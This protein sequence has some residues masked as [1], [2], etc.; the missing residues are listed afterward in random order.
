M[1]IADF[2]IITCFIKYV[3]SEYSDYKSLKTLLLNNH[4]TFNN[5]SIISGKY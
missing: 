5:T 3:L 1:S 4:A 2:F